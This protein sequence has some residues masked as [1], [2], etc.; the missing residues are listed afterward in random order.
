MLQHI[1]DSHHSKMNSRLDLVE[2]I[3]RVCNWREDTL[4]DV[5]EHARKHRGQD[6]VWSSDYRRWEH[7]LNR[8]R[9]DSDRSRSPRSKLKPERPFGWGKVKSS[10]GKKINIKI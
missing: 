10:E 5:Q 1:E 2:Y 6:P 3:C 9:S 4:E 7:N 8:F